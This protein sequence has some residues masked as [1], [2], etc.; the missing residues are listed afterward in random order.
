MAF[1]TFKDLLVWQK[2][3]ALTKII[4]KITV[5][6]PASEKFSLANQI[7]RAAVSVPSNLVEGLRRKSLKDSL[8]FYNI[9]EGSLEEVKYQLLLSFELRFITQEEYE[10]AADLAEQT[11]KLL[12]RFIQS[13]KNNL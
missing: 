9:A 12:Y 11:G 8:N 10:Q 3:H 6:F 1:R 7:R 13:Q 2:A 4:Y 5:A